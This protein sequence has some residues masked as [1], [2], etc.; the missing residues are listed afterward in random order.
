MGQYGVTDNGFVIK[1]M[2]VIMEEIHQ[3]L[4]N[5]FGYNTRLL[6]PS[7][8]DTLV[9]TFSAQ[10]YDL[11]ETAQKDYY[12]KYVLFSM[13]AC[14][15]V[16]RSVAYTPCIVPEMTERKSEPESLLQPIHCRSADWNQWKHS[17]YLGKLFILSR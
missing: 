9:T 12:S 1:R 7:F 8:L 16:G 14:P 10:I 6:R 4:T 13:E 3:D 15:E 11:W 2:D 5:G 17:P